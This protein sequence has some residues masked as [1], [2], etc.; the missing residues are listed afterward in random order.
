M[1]HIFPVALFGFL[2]YI[3]V[4]IIL[5]QNRREREL[6][7]ELSASLDRMLREN[8]RRIE[9]L[10]RRMNAAS[11]VQPLRLGQHWNTLGIAP[12]R[13]KAVIQRAYKKAALKAH[14]DHG[15]TDAKFVKLTEARKAALREIGVAA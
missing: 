4:R 9:E 7:A 1:S 5:A 6:D 15:G 11:G 13:D 2:C 8:Q 10:Q 14:P 12:T 3:F